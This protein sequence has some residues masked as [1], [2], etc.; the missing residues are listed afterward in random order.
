MCI[1]NKNKKIKIKKKL[2]IQNIFFLDCEFAVECIFYLLFNLEYFKIRR[3][4]LPME[5]KVTSSLFS[6]F[7]NTPDLA[8]DQQNYFCK[9]Q[10]TFVSTFNTPIIHR[11]SKTNDERLDTHCEV[12]IKKKQGTG[13]GGEVAVYNIKGR[14]SYRK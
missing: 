8:P 13:W 3:Q 10:L 6:I 11:V 7:M 1:I 4:Y 5:L 14:S 2:G 9:M 12:K